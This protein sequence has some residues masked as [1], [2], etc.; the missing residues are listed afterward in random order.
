MAIDP[1]CAADPAFSSLDAE[2]LHKA[3]ENA[4]LDGDGKRQL[5]D[6]LQ[7]N[8]DV[9]TSSLGQT[10]ILT[11]KILLT[12]DNPIK[13]KSYR[14]STV[15]LQV[16]KELGE[17]MLPDD[18]IKPL[19]SAWASP[20][21]LISKKDGGSPDSVLITSNLTLTLYPLYKKS[22][23]HLLDLLYFLPSTSKVDTGSA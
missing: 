3:V 8:T 4:H 9:C 14:A 11:H 21:V 22:W 16:M 1:R 18:I 23:T 17:E 10:K 15:K 6:L 7:R 13:Q 20:V 19:S 2:L 12:Q 5:C